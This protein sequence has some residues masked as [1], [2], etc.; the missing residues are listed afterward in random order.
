MQVS[1]KEKL[2]SRPDSRKVYPAKELVVEPGG[3]I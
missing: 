2:T 3:D 1:G